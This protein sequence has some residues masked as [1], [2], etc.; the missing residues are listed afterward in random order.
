MLKLGFRNC[1]SCLLSHR[2]AAAANLAL[3]SFLYCFHSFDFLFLQ[4]SFRRFYLLF[5]FPFK[6][7]VCLTFLQY[8]PT[9][10]KFKEPICDRYA[11]LVSVTIVWVYATILTSSGAYRNSRG[12]S[13]RVDHSKLIGNASW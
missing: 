12:E 11:V 5:S 1:F 2:Q 8:L 13:C 4:C 7:A 9:F 10:I 6:V 3:V